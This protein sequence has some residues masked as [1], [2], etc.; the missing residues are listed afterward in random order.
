M[1]WHNVLAF[2]QTLRSVLSIRREYFG[3]SIVLSSR[4]SEF[5]RR[6]RTLNR[7][8]IKPGQNPKYP[9]GCRQVCRRR[10][11]EKPEGTIDGKLFWQSTKENGHRISCGQ[12]SQERFPIAAR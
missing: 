6:R 2:K 5:W 1:K 9:A 8:F 12:A 11:M 7:Q 4:A 10:K 3:Q